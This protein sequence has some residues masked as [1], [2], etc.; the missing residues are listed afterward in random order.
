M[1]LFAGSIMLN[2]AVLIFTSFT[3]LGQLTWRVH[4]YEQVVFLKDSISKQ[5]D[6]ADDLLLVKSFYS[7]LLYQYMIQIQQT[8]NGHPPN[9]MKLISNICKQNVHDQYFNKTL[10]DKEFI[11]YVVKCDDK[12]TK[13]KFLYSIG[14]IYFG[15]PWYQLHVCHTTSQI[16][17]Y[18]HTH[19]A[20]LL[21][22]ESQW[23]K[24]SSPCWT[25]LVHQRRRS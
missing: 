3:I 7:S 5:M 11:C 15:T 19:I 6:F 8:T 25:L 24:P 20:N 9:K 22:D 18:L 2:S 12:D 1:I 14:S 13:W 23:A 4:H 10:D 16:S 17:S 21:R